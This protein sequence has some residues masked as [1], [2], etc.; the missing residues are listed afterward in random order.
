VLEIDITDD[1]PGV[2]GEQVREGVGLGNTRARLDAL[3][4][5]ASTLSLTNVAGGGARVSVRLP[6]RTETDAAWR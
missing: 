6:F 5:G 2:T 3:Y 1:G 4:P